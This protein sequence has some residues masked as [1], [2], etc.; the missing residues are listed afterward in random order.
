MKVMTSLRALLALNM[1]EQRRISGISQAKLAEKVNTST[2][3]IG[4][5]ETGKKF[6]SPEM[7]ERIA[8]ALAIDSPDL[9]SKK[10]YSPDAIKKFEEQVLQDI[11]NVMAARLK[12][13]Q[14]D[15]QRKS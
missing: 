12:E 1:K 13:L 5:I 10:D 6:P 3:Y 2:H 7:L 15:T 9:F 4:M 14:Q 8:A 11:E